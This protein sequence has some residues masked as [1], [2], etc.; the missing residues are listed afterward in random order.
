MQKC[1]WG[2]SSRVKGGGGGYVLS[3]AVDSLCWDESEQAGSKG[4]GGGRGFEMHMSERGWVGGGGSRG[5]LL[6]RLCGGPGGVT[7][8][9]SH[10]AT[11][12]CLGKH[13]H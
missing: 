5:F 7:Q 4:R 6:W 10:S 11:Y 12:P 9:L 13:P 2:E 1:K 3:V 8:V